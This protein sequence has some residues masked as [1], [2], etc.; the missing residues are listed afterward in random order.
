MI[1]LVT[2]FASGGEIFGKSS[3]LFSLTAFGIVSPF[4]GFL[5]SITFGHQSKSQSYKIKKSNLMSVFFFTFFNK[6]VC[7]CKVVLLGKLYFFIKAYPNGF[8]VS[9]TVFTRSATCCLTKIIQRC[10]NIS[11]KTSI[12]HKSV[13]Y[14]VLTPTTH[15][16]YNPICVIICR[17]FS[18]IFLF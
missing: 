5:F 14:T 12:L 8:K 3:Q 13:I 15:L 1:Y 18:L 9:K 6:P 2:E 16:T 11:S 4:Q 17:T 7:F 10:K